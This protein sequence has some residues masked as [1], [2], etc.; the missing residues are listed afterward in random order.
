MID[1]NEKGQTNFCRE[2][3][4]YVAK[5]KALEADLHREEQLRP[6]TWDEHWMRKEIKRLEQELSIARA[7]ISKE[8]E[9]N[10]VDMKEITRL[11]STLAV[12][13]EDVAELL[14]LINPD[15]YDGAR[16]QVLRLLFR[17]NRALATPAVVD[18]SEFKK[19]LDKTMKDSHDILKRP[20]M[21]DEPPAVEP[22]VNNG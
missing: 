8:A 5:I 6:G 16:D 22:E 9:N 17:L 4:A 21:D 1:D 14:P 20:E 7:I 2:C 19:T 15:A 11:S 13:K 10:V 12:M 18:D 3:E